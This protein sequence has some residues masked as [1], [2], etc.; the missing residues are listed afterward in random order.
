VCQARRSRIRR[1]PRPREAFRGRS[2]VEFGLTRPVGI[3]SITPRARIRGRGR[4]RWGC[5]LCYRRSISIQLMRNRLF[6]IA[7]GLITDLRITDY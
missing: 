1:R 5:V 3:H 6:F 7:P 2:G 4:R